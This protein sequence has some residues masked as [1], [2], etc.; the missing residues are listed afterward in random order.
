MLKLKKPTIVWLAMLMFLFTTQ[1]YSF[2]QLPQYSGKKTLQ[3]LHQ[4]VEVLFDNHGIPHIYAQSLE[5][6]YYALGYVHAQERISQF[7]LFRRLGTGTLGEVLGAFGA[8][9]DVPTRTVGIVE[10]AKKS[11]KAL[12]DGP[13]TPFKKSMNS[14]LAG[15][16]AYLAGLT[17]ETRP[18]DLLPTPAAY[19]LEDIYSWINYFL[20]GFAAL[21]VSS[22]AITDQLVSRLDNPAYLKDLNIQ[23][24]TPVNRS[25]PPRPGSKFFKGKYKK[26]KRIGKKL[27]KTLANFQDKF[28]IVA[29]NSNGWALSGRLTTTG[30]PMHSSD[31]H[32]PLSKPDTF[33]EAQLVYPGQ[34]LYGNWIPFSPF[35]LIGHNRDIAWGTT[36]MLHDDTDLYRERLN[37]ANPNQVWVNDHWQD[38]KTRAETIR[39]IQSDGTLKDSIFEV[40]ITR[41]GPIIN[42]V[43]GNIKGE[44]PISL[45]F[46]GF[47]FNES[48][49][50]TFFNIANSKNLATFRRSVRG[51]TGI[52]AN[53]QYADKKG[54][55]AWFTAARFL[56]RPEHVNS[57]VILDGASGKDEPLGYYPF[58]S[59]PRSINPPSGFVYSNN[60]QIGRVEGLLYPGYY[61]AGTRSKRIKKILRSGKRFS[62]EDLR[63]LFE[64]DKSPTFKK[65][66]RVVL[67]TLASHPVLNKTANHAKAAQILQ[68]W[69]GDHPL[70]T[71]GPIVFYQLFYQLLKYTM[72]DEVG[73]DLFQSFFTGVTPLYDV[74]DRS[75]EGLLLNRSSI[76]FDDVSTTHVKET[77]RDIFAKAYDAAVNALVEFGSMEQVW[78]EVHQQFYANLPAA[79][80]G[81]TEGNLGPYPFKGGINTLNKTE[82]DLLA[83][84]TSGNY[85]VAKTSG[86]VNR[87]LVDFSDI[88]KNSKGVLPTGQSGV[89]NSPFYQDQVELYNNGLLR[90]MLMDREDIEKVSTVLLLEKPPYPAPNVGDIS[91]P[92]SA[93]AGD[94]F[95]NYSVETVYNADEYIWTLPVG[96]TQNGTGAT[97]TI[98]TTDGTIN[99]D[100]GA[101]FNGGN[102]TVAGKSNV[103]GTGSTSALAVAKC[104][105]SRTTNNL[106]EKLTSGSLTVYPNPVTGTKPVQI[107]IEGRDIKGSHINITIIDERGSQLQTVSAKLTNGVA[108]VPTTSLVSGKYIFKIQVGAEVVRYKVIK[109]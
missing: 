46:T 28:K 78:G 96:V 88:G 62:Q 18:K 15:V 8:S 33:Y 20:Y 36:A 43:D 51:L 73:S 76:W 52:G 77:R 17:P 48:Y 69:K 68:S 2:A 66:S 70:D 61:V 10:N 14:Y 67:R 91:G 50:S 22:D 108:T 54:N 92:V 74:L 44:D 55:I 5:D 105:N 82:L 37:P 85:S 64:D 31:G 32:T 59:N 86:P 60:N 98:A 93:C 95:V 23:N 84:A 13:N 7:E 47:K 1:H 30:K 40:K 102:I 79:F 94:L 9:F 107:K 34:D 16:N 11:A 56:R 99:V 45:F 41:H 90:A 24:G 75:F 104:A 27:L 103:A 83:V 101:D 71:K 65:I 72:E 109:H 80:T 35:A 19:T 29:K 81:Q 100:F 42:N 53:I 3:G 57:K 39:I 87:T 89:P 4:K 38:M 97:G 106:P 58:K 21:E 6:A 49:L 26:R 25:F 63:K 12:R